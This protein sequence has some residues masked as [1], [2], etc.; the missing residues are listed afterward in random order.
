MEGPN[1]KTFTFLRVEGFREEA[2]IPRAYPEIEGVG[3]LGGRSLAELINSEQTATETALMKAGRPSA[4]I[5]F[6]E[7]S[8]YT[9]G[10]ALYLLEVATAFAGGL[11][12]IDPFDQPGVEEGKQLTYAMMDRKGY[13]KRKKEL[14]RIKKKTKYI[15]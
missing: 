14:E 7:L 12:N 11:Y 8:A 6:P 1:D 3:Y 5:T 15:I 4:R 13:E 9:V 2:P 10:Q